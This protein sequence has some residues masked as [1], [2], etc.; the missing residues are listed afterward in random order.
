MIGRRPPEAEKPRQVVLPT[1]ERC[2]LVV[3]H[4]R[5]MAGDR[6]RAEDPPDRNGFAEPLEPVR[7]EAL[8]QEAS[9]E[10]GSRSRRDHDRAW[11][12]RSMQPPCQV[13]GFAEHRL[14][15]GGAVPDEI[16]RDDDSRLDPHPHRER[17]RHRH[18]GRRQPGHGI[19]HCK[20]RTDRALGV[21]L[22]RMRVAEEHEDPVA[23]VARDR[24]P[25]P[26]HA[27]GTGGLV[28]AD[29]VAQLLQLESVGEARRVDEVAEQHRELAAFGGGAPHRGLHVA[30]RDEPATTRT[31]E[32]EADRIRETAGRTGQ[33]W[34]GTGRQGLE[35]SGLGHEAFP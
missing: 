4:S 12:S 17:L 18:R 24:S 27:L 6:A 35:L 28:G 10:Q 32:A 33:A 11:Q 22:M 20:T 1:D 19:D 7:S 34:R 16:A 5:E 26:L 8:T 2:A 23:H 3:A 21:V 14:L 13:H 9:A 31:A 25:V 30:A 15:L 29:D